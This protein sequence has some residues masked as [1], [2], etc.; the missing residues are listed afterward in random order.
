MEAIGIGPFGRMKNGGVLGS[1]TLSAAEV[2]LRGSRRVQ[3]PW[4]RIDFPEIDYRRVVAIMPPIVS[5]C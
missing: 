1:T 3:G 5:F 2:L 4:Q